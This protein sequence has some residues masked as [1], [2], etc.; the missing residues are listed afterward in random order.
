MAER[1][2]YRMDVKPSLSRFKIDDG[3]CFVIIFFYAV[4]APVIIVFMAFIPA[5][6]RTFFSISYSNLWPI[7]N[8]I[9]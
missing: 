8:N 4:T 9:F 5:M 2:E 3:G 6:D 7:F 1:A